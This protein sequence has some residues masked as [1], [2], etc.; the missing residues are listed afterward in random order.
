MKKIGFIGIGAMGAPMAL[1]LH[2]AGF[3]VTVFNRTKE[4][5]VTLKEKGISIGLDIAHTVQDKDIVITM[6]SNDEAVKQVVLGEKGV[7]KHIA[8]TTILV[9]MST[10]S[11]DT[12]L[13]IAT[14]MKQK[15]VS[16]IDAPVSGDSNAAKRA[17]L[18]V[19]GGG[20]LQVFESLQSVFSAIGKASYYFGENG[21]GS[22]AKLVINLLMGVTMQG[23]SEA[24][25]LAEK[26]NLDRK[27]VLQMM[28]QT[29]VASPFIGFKE[30][31]LMAEKFPIA[32][33]LKHMHK[34]LE[35]ILEQ[36]RKTEAE[37][38]LPATMATHQSYTNALNS[39][40]GEMDVS[41]VFKQL[42]M[43]SELVKK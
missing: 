13:T 36:A 24:L 28:K 41:A 39:G 11:P 9:D 26:F 31:L 32:F 42:L 23:I 34:D 4:R 6:L 20:D 2:N 35:L 3:D 12:S 10:V 38:A 22:R 21:S 37:S 33:A 40:F 16:F 19:L 27:T 14:A 15:G 43:E 8:P 18:V 1:N 30:E 7:L 5:I 17:G 25:V 29:A